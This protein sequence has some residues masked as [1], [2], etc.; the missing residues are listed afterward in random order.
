MIRQGTF[1]WMKP[2]NSIWPDAPIVGLT[3]IPIEELIEEEFGLEI[4]VEN[5]ETLMYV[6]SLLLFD[7]FDPA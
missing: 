7:L 2:V 1:Q 3:S 4:K 5:D 6:A